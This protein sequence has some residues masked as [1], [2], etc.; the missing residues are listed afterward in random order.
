MKNDCQYLQIREGCTVSY[1]DYKLGT[2]L[3][4]NALIGGYTAEGLPV[5]IRPSAYY[6]P[7]SNRLVR[8]GGIIRGKG[9]LLVSL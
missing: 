5:Y 4:P 9:R 7:G 8:P 3:L 1:V 6:I 2:T